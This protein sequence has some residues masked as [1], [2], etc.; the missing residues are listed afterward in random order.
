M[1]FAATLIYSALASRPEA[2]VSAQVRSSPLAEEEGELATPALG[3]PAAGAS[4]VAAARTPAAATAAARAPAPA[5]RSSPPRGHARA[6]LVGIAPSL[7]T[8]RLDLRQDPVVLRPLDGDLLADEFLDG[9]DLEGARLV[10]EADRFAGGAGARGAPDPVNVVLRVLGHVPVDDVGHSFDVQAA[11]GDVRRHENGQLAVLE[12]VQDLEPLLLLHVA[13]QRLGLPAVARQ[14][15]LEAARFLSRVREHE[16]TAAALALEEAQEQAE[17]LLAPR[18]IENLDDV[19]GRLLERR[20][21]DLGRV[22]HEF[23]GQLHHAKGQ[24]RRVEEGLALLRLGQPAQDEAQVGDEPHVE[25]AVG[26]VDHE[27]FD[28]LGRPDVL[29]EIVDETAR[30]AHQDVAGLGQVL[31]LLVV[32][33]AAVDGADPQPRVGAQEAGVG[34]DL[35]DQLARGRDDQHARRGRAAFGRGGMPQATREGGDQEGRRLAGARLGLARNV[36]ALEG[37]RQRAF[38]DRR[39]GDEARVLDAAHDRL[40]QIEWLEVHWAH[41]VAWGLMARPGG[42]WR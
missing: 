32:V 28:P 4:A 21:G 6:L 17:L 35:D 25:H 34:L 33:D 38:L 3:T 41:G 23:P 29:L 39:H 24:G 11:R 26:L 13:G 18:V 12:V 1:V 22:V 14:P 15:V 37:E 20:D 9:L 36:L 16:D 27:H 7:F 2:S 30:R 42:S 5:A 8:G 19:L 10:G 31:A 40:G